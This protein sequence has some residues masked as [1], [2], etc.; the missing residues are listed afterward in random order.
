[1][2]T[3]TYFILFFLTGECHL[4]FPRNAVPS[5][6]GGQ[7]VLNTLGPLTHQHSACPQVCENDR[8][9]TIHLLLSCEISTKFVA[10]TVL[11]VCCTVIEV[12]DDDGGGG[13]RLESRYL[14]SILKMEATSCFEYWYPLN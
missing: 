2:P 6:S 7:S 5:S 14:T 4:K 12:D 1:V 13:G 8:S 9:H 10:V 3:L 11:S